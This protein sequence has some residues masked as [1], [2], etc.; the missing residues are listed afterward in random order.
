LK[1]ASGKDPVIARSAERSPNAKV[2][3]AMS[4]AEILRDD[5]GDDDPSALEPSME[6]ILASIRR[7]LADGR[8]LSG[9]EARFE[10][11]AS[12]LPPVGGD[13]RPSV[14][15]ESHRLQAMPHRP[16]EE[17]A[18]PL[19]SATT[20]AS[21]AAAFRYLVASRFAQSTD[22]VA[23]LTRE[24]IRPM[25]EAWLDAHL[26]RLVE[27]LVATEIARISRGE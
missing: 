17:R 3:K 25:L 8:G 16:T 14:G 5:R 19:A 4:G 22:L 9:T 6:E 21:V 20:E 10:P 13:E 7:I 23:D 15:H 1:S 24:M 12:G 18:A 26:P 27:R 2:R 11:D